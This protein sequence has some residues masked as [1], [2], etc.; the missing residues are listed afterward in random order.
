MPKTRRRLVFSRRFTLLAVAFFCATLSGAIDE[1]PKSKAPRPRG[2]PT[3]KPTTR[4]TSD[5]TPEPTPGTVL[6]ERRRLTRIPHAQRT[7]EEI[8]ALAGIDFLLAIGNA[9]GP[10]AS[11]LVDVVGYQPLPSD[12]QLPEDPPRPKPQA[13]I[14]TW[15]GERPHFAVGELKS[16]QFDVRSKSHLREFPAVATWML[17]E[18]RVLLIHAPTTPQPNW[19]RRDA[20]L[21]I[22]IRADKPTIVGGTLL[23]ALDENVR[24]EGPPPEDK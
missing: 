20:C 4:P 10:R 11:G 6:A 22:R 9:D 23:E 8:A 21:V 16:E 5:P 2:K 14:G 19:I 3:S 13:D 24:D 15:V 7:T 12:E 17:T 18:D 1:K